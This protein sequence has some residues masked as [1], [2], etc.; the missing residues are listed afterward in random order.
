M[1]VRFYKAVAKIK[2]QLDGL[3][4][5]WGGTGTLTSWVFS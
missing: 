1:T 2:L 5:G 4:L 3:L